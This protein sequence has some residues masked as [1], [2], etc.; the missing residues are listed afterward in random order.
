MKFSNQNLGD[1][2]VDIVIKN[3]LSAARSLFPEQTSEAE[4]WITARLA[5]YG[6]DYAKYRAQQLYGTATDWLSNPAILLGLGL[7]A[8]YLIFKR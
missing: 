4:A 1:E 8:G 5:N 2:T 3:I 6:I 7:G